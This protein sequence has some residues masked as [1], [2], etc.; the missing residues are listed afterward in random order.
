MRRGAGFVGFSLLAGV[1]GVRAG[2]W[3]RKA[4]IVLAMSPPLTL[5]LTGWVVA[6]TKRAPLVFNI[7]DV[8]PDAAVRTGAIANPRVIAAAEWLERLS[9]R[10]SR[11]VT[12]L[13]DDLRANVVAKMRPGDAA[14]VHVIPNFVDT[15]QLHPADR[16][17]NYR[18]ELGIGGGPVVLYAGNVGFSQSLDLML[19]AARECPD[20][21]FVINGDG[22]ARPALEAAAADLGNVRFV[23]YQPIERLPEVLASGDVHVVPLRAGLGDVS[24]P[25]KTY[26]SLAVARPVVASIDPH[27]AIPRLLAAS[28][29]G[30]SV[31]P[32][33]LQAFVTAIRGLLDDRERAV[34]LGEAGRRW[35][36][37]NASPSAVGAAY[38]QLMTAIAAG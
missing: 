4:D 25:S 38:D 27:T 37:E 2:G 20:A 21:V 26:S 11:A 30:I 15:H 24:V 5:G 18:A 14:R 16:M 34:G 29:G 6:L 33:D 35:V 31:P 23:G 22:A 19:G 8:F 3:F 9:Y 12:V 10:R 36:V 17:T 32:G 1:G 7:Q 28:G 13:S